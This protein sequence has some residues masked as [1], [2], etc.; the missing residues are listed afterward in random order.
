MFRKSG[1]FRK[2]DVRNT[3]CGI[4]VIAVYILL[5]LYALRGLGLVVAEKEAELA[6]SDL[7]EIDDEANYA[8]TQKKNYHSS[9]MLHS[10]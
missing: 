5:N 9:F 10:L 3:V 4:N 2:R 7:P 1:Q 6:K 8:S